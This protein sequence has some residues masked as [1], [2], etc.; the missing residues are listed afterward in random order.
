M[1][2]PTG[3]AFRVSG[4][5]ASMHTS[6]LVLYAG[7]EVAV[8]VWADSPAA[9]P[10]LAV[11]DARARAAMR[12]EWD[13]P[14][15]DVRDYLAHHVEDLDEVHMAELSPE[16][17]IA[18]LHLSR[19]GLYPDDPRHHAVFDYTTGRDITDNLIAVKF[20]AAGAVVQIAM[21]S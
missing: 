19:V 20:D 11:F 12:A 18:G 7:R 6:S 9:T 8:D 15:S 1:A 13:E 3:A 16:A 21:E 14:G 4:H 2:A 5:T 17:F 10:E